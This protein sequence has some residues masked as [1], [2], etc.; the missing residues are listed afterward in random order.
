MLFFLSTTRLED[1]MTIVRCLFLRWELLCIQ[2]LPETIVRLGGVHNDW[3]ILRWYK[4]LKMVNRCTQY[5]FE[6]GYIRLYAQIVRDWIFTCK[7]IQK[8]H[9]NLCRE[10]GKLLLCGS[11]QHTTWMIPPTKCHVCWSF[12]QHKCHS[13][14]P[15]HLFK[16]I[17]VP[18][19]I[20]DAAFPFVSNEQILVTARA[21]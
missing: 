10:C 4:S 18:L 5:S 14:F 20:T 16:V 12:W 6:E 8:D 3:H 2:V 21:N 11:T 19:E 1:L 9:W 15:K 13:T 7:N 17:P